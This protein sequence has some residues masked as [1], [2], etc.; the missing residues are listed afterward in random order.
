MID[1][2][3]GLSSEL[4]HIC[5]ASARGCKIF[6]DKI[7]IHEETRRVAREFGTEPVIAALNGGE[8]YELLFT[9]PVIAFDK[10]GNRQEITIIGHMVDEAEGASMITAEGQTIILQAQ[11]WNPLR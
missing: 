4:L 6:A 7:P 10:I 3:D 1:I 5:S 9:V 8:D 11:G 2:S